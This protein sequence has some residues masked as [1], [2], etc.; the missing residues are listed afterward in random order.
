[1]QKR[2][3]PL[4]RIFRY[5]KCVRNSYGVIIAKKSN[6]SAKLMEV[7]FIKKSNKLANNTIF[8]HLIV[9]EI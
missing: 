7:K 8:D 4:A 3:I 9:H 6:T 1:M 5:I 2:E